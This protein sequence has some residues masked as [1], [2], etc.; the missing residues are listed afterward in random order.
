MKHGVYRSGGCGTSISGACSR[1]MDAIDRDGGKTERRA[2]RDINISKYQQ[3]LC[4]AKGTVWVPRIPLHVADSSSG[5]AR[6]RW[7]DVDS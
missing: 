1:A 5:G 4:P 6:F 3:E 2:T 7:Y